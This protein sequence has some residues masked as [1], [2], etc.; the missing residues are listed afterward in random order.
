MYERGRQFSRTCLARVYKDEALFR[1]ALVRDPFKRAVSALGEVAHREAARRNKTACS[2]TTEELI[3][4]LESIMNHM[5]QDATPELNVLDGFHF[6]AQTHF[7]ID[8][9]GQKLPIDYIGNF[10]NFEEEASF[11][12]QNKSAELEFMSGPS[13]VHLDGCRL[14]PDAVPPKLKENIC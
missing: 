7:M 12:L 10:S 14:D 13:R 3:S 1:R 11:I 6:L 9:E 5:K 8:S 2:N 4:D